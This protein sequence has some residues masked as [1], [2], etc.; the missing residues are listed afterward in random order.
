[1]S[2]QV[3]IRPESVSMRLVNIE[4]M[5]SSTK[6][7]LI[8]D[9]EEDIGELLPYLATEIKGCTYIHGSGQLNYMEQGH[10]IAIRPLQITVTAVEDEAEARRICE[11]LISLINSVHGRR[12]QIAPALRKQGRVGPLAVYRALP[13]TNC[14]RC[15]ES[16][17]LA[18]AARV[19]GRDLLPWLCTPLQEQ[20]YEKE[21][22]LLLDLLAQAD[23]DI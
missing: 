8:I 10:I 11:Q 16:S 3:M 1:M 2:G 13:G 23:Y 22:R 9:L 17:C 21:K 5:P 20:Q 18:F 19:A 6:F 14:G 15:G 4:C 12:S 7:N